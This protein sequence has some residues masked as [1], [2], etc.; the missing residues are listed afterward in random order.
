LKFDERLG[1]EPYI[2]IRAAVESDKP[3]LKNHGGKFT[4]DE[5]EGFLNIYETLSAVYYKG[6]IPKDLLFPMYSHE[7]QKT[8]GNREIQEYLKLV[9][10]E[11]PSFYN[12]SESLAKSM[13]EESP[14]PTPTP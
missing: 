7:F 9:R 4:E 5:L 12:G 8:F 6:L 2:N 10:K 11:D 14:P 1:R 13:K 3:I